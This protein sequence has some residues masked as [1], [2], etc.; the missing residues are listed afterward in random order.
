M[1]TTTRHGNDGG[2]RSPRF[3]RTVVALATLVAAA[4]LPPSRSRADNPIIQTKYT[5]DPAPLVYDDTVWLYT[6]HD[7]DNAVGFTMYDWLLYSSKDLVN[8]TD[9]GVIA[10]VR[11]PHKTFKWADGVNAW[12]PQVIYRNDK[13]YLY[14]PLPR[15]GHMVIG[16][17]V[18]DRPTGPFVDAL[19][20]PLIDNPSSSYDIDPSVFI[21]NDGQAYLYWGH[22]PPLFYVK[23]NPDMISYSGGIVQLT[24]P[25]T[26]EEGPWIYRRNNQY[27]LAFASTCCPEGIGYAMSGSPTGPWT[28]RG[29]IMDPNSASSGNHPGIID[30][31]GNTYL[32]GFNYAIQ[33]QREGARRGE[34]R[35]VCVDRMTYNADGTIQKLPFWG[36]SS[37]PQVGTLNPFVQTEAETI[38]WAW[39]VRTETCSE[40][41]MNVSS[42]NN[43]DYIKVAGVDFGAG[44]ASL[45]ARVASGASGGNIQI[46]LGGTTG[47]LVG[48]CA[49]PGTG[50][51][52]SWTTVTCNVTGATGVRDLYFVFTGGS[53]NLLN[54]NWWRFQP[55]G[56]YAVAV[57]RT[58]NGS[59]TSTPAGIDCG[60][61]CSGTFA[62]GSTVTLTAVPAAG[63]SFAGW[64]GACVGTGTC[65][66]SMTADHSVTATFSAPT[67][68][69]SV[70]AGG[71]ASG[72][73]V[74]DAY[75]VGG[76]TYSTTAA[77]DS[78]Q[79]TGTVPPQ[80]VLQTERYGTFTYTIPGL[81]PGSPYAVTLYFVESYWT[82][83][84]QR[85]FSVAVNG[86]P[87]LSGFDIFAAAGGANKAIARTFNT[88]ASASGQVVIAF[89][90]GSVD[91]A[92]VVGVAVA[93]GSGPTSYNLAVTRSG[94]GAGTVAGGPID[95]GATCSATVAS[96]AAVT[97]TATAA[98]GSTF[99][100][101]SG[102]CVGSGACVLSMTAARAVTAAF[103]TGGGTS[104][105]GRLRGV[106]SGRCLDVPNAS[107]SNGARLTIWDCNGGANQQWTQTTSNT[108]Q[109]YGS[110]CLEFPAGSGAGTQVQIWD[111]NGGTNQQWR[112]NADGTITSIASGLCLD[113]TGQG[114]ANSTA[115]VV[116]T[117]NGGQNQRWSR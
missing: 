27:Y 103:N 7:E 86:A 91:H 33:L 104:S 78:A 60:S 36:R 19:G 53:G 14:G 22:Q 100:G 1:T 15:N 42:I 110:K 25:Q 31:R 92:K 43:G 13:F 89:T 57:T 116:W 61:T 107:Q 23:L 68:T 117:C 99:A 109:V 56:R 73:F 29:S 51:W 106:Q 101:W 17:A 66:L 4:L 30:F 76:S 47:P 77:I 90:A 39:D 5:A 88:T 87:V 72:T 58:G 114:T 3:Q 111:C 108:F 46:R 81:T 67:G 64:S 85:L 49:V 80:S 37:A 6:S 102:D 69:V 71:A 59:V 50:G 96:G 2:V 54:F 113:V 93:S 38:A 112:F 18:A 97:L 98:S 44:A 84:G 12:A 55:A 79:L 95:C 94:S 20:R 34:R 63:A 40:G 41:G 10:G 65:I 48:T 32:F 24:R 26:F 11:D 83:A 21:D 35:S 115:V 82:A 105:T 45:S 52:Q 28:Y 74:A 9:H 8:W 62:S 75:Y 16:V 70:N